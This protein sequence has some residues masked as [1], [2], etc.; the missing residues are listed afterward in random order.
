VYIYS[1][2][3]N[4]IAAK[5]QEVT[6]L[7]KEYISNP[8]P[9]SKQK[10]T[11]ALRDH[12]DYAALESKT[13]SSLKRVDYSPVQ[14]K[15]DQILNKVE[16][17]ELNA[18]IIKKYPA[19]KGENGSPLSI[20]KI[21]KYIKNTPARPLPNLSNEWAQKTPWE[22]Y[23]EELKS[24]ISLA[25]QT[26][27]GFQLPANAGRQKAIQ[28]ALLARIDPF[29][30][31]LKAP[32]YSEAVRSD[33]IVLK[34]Y[35]YPIDDEIFVADTEEI[36][37]TAQVIDKISEIINLPSGVKY[38]LVS[39]AIGSSSNKTSTLGYANRTQGGHSIVNHIRKAERTDK[40]KLKP[41]VENESWHSTHTHAGVGS[42]FSHTAAHE[43]G[44]LVAYDIWPNDDQMDNEYRQYRKQQVSL[45][46]KESAHEHFAEA[47]AKY[48]LTGKA[49]PEFLDLLRSRGLLKSQQSS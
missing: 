42:Y 29:T 21:E 27:R 1:D 28:R 17:A 33:G 7:A 4:K 14:L 26:A 44:H 47:F 45:Y 41:F 9:E 31:N 8:S 40:K 6:E 43:I 25:E 36:E 46:G 20:A 39:T 5:T 23:Q 48:V 30:N 2:V 16:I 18:D 19:K 10:Y 32:D 24:T 22:K 15:E 35:H 49:T 37:V 34:V 11:E 13:Q 38:T 12:L 3:I